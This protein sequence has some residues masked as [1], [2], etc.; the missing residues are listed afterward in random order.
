MEGVKGEEREEGKERK[1]KEKGKEKGKRINGME[2]KG[3]EIKE[4]ERKGNERTR[5]W[6]VEAEKEGGRKRVSEK[7]GG[8]GG[9]EAG[10]C[11]E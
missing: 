8:M 4:T 2:R 1:G 10:R 9:R 7:G 3:N 6:G 11:R 5:I